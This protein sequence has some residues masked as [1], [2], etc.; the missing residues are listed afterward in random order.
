MKAL[1]KIQQGAR[2]K[3]A[4]AKP[5]PKQKKGKD[6][7]YVEFN[8][9]G[10]PE[11]QVAVPRSETWTSESLG[12]CIR[13]FTANELGFIGDDETKPTRAMGLHKGQSYANEVKGQEEWLIDGYYMVNPTN[14]RIMGFMS[15]GAFNLLHASKVDATPEEFCKKYDIKPSELLEGID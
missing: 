13:Q 4:K 8:L 1:S 6:F 7:I 15:E 10:M 11:G 5:Q 9:P 12:K 2:R 3:T 14:K